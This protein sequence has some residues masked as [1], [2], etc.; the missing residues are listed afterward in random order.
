MV[1]INGACRTEKAS[2]RVR[3]VNEEESGEAAAHLTNGAHSEAAWYT[4]G[5]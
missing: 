3:H 1:I 4:A 5:L 2:G